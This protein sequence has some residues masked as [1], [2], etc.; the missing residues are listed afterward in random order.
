MKILLYK[1]DFRNSVLLIEI[2]PL[3]FDAHLNRE[4]KPQRKTQKHFTGHT[5]PRWKLYHLQRMVVLGPLD[6]DELGSTVP[7]A[8][9]EEWYMGDTWGIQWEIHLKHLVQGRNSAGLEGIPACLNHSHKTVTK[10]LIL[11]KKLCFLLH[12]IFSLYPLYLA[13]K[14]KSK[15]YLLYVAFPEALWPY[16]FNYHFPKSVT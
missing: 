8:R 2:L 3:V 5:H 15:L 1:L 9:P 6:T 14:G 10:N 4:D 12:R 16:F 11:K 7:R 13:L